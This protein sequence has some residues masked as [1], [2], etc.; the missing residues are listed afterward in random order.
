MQLGRRLAQ[1]Q[2]DVAELVAGALE[3]GREALERRDRALGD[4]DEARGTLALLGRERLRR[5]RCGLGELDDVPQPLALVAAALL[6]ARP[7]GLRCPRRSRAA[8]RAAPRRRPRSR[9]APRGGAGPRAAR[10]TRRAPRRGAGCSSPQNR[11]STS[12]WYAGPREPPLLEL[13]RHRDHALDGGRD[14]LAGGRAAPRVRARAPVGEDAP[15]DDERVLVLGPQLRTPSSSSSSSVRQ[16]SSAS[17]YASLARRPDEPRR[18]SCRAGARPPA[19]GSSCPRR[20][21]R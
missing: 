11:S 13:P 15:R 4:A 20:S 12:S 2:L 17:T 1:A 9:S 8:R 5:G 7:R 16:S 14:V 6:V 18:P 10:A 19:R 21:R 3:L